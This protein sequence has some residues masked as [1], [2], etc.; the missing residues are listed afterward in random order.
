M[1]PPRAVLRTT[2]A[3]RVSDV[4]SGPVSEARAA[5]DGRVMSVIHES[6]TMHFLTLIKDLVRGGFSPFLF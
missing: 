6:C 1:T 3:V 2:P 5:D 4:G